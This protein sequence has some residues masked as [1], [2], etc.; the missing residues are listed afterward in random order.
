MKGSE[1]GFLSHWTELLT[2]PSLAVSTPL[3]C[4]P[5]PHLNK[6]GGEACTESEVEHVT[7]YTTCAGRSGGTRG[8]S[9]RL[10]AGRRIPKR[11]GLP[12]ERLRLGRPRVVGGPPGR[13]E[14]PLPVQ[15][16][17]SP[18]RRLCPS[19]GGSPPRQPPPVELQVS[20][21]LPLKSFGI[22]WGKFA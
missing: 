15:G 10:G 8:D 19:G 20:F 18:R 3:L 5:S 11:R 7:W 21:L 4:P 13:H 1:T 2:Q 9:R 6:G 14:A 16:P 12:G 22:T 17:P